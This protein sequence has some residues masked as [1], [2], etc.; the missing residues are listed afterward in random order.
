MYREKDQDAW[1][2]MD[3]SANQAMALNPAGMQGFFCPKAGTYRYILDSATLLRSGRIT[4]YLSSCA[5]SQDP[6]YFL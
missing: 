2:E 4:E 6:V 5:K 1:I 3:F